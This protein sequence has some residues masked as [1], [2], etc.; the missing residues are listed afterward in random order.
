MPCRL[1]D[2]IHTEI[3]V[4]FVLALET[5]APLLLIHIRS[6]A[7]SRKTLPFP[8]AN[9][10]PRTK[11]NQ[12][13]PNDNSVICIGVYKN[14][15][16]WRLER[17]DRKWKSQRSGGEGEEDKEE[18]KFQLGEGGKAKAILEWK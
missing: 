6:K 12:E 10:G 14:I 18:K 3:A 2:M 7:G 11:A 4:H 13:I 15:P 17:A 5:L 1:D 8:T 9:E 16:E